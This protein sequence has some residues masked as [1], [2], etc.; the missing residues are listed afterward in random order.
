M[1]APG[2]PLV[3]CF[4]NRLLGDD[5]VGWHVADRLAADRRFRHVDVVTRHQLTPELAEDLSRASR[6]VFVDACVSSP[7]GA[8]DR[9]KVEV[10][11]ETARP[12]RWSHE[13]T[14]QALAGLAATLFGRLPPIHVVTVGGASFAAG[15]DLSV[16]VEAAV[17]E[18]VEAVAAVVTGPA[19]S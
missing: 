4:G 10:T 18:L 19:S 2:R 3:V 14:P 17:P 16:A 8:V 6:V 11:P 12:L 9:S 13:L 1:E 7:P 5:A 15:E